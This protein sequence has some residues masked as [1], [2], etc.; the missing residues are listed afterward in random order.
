MMYKMVVCEMALC[1]DISI[2]LVKVLE[3]ES[4]CQRIQER[5]R[6]V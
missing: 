6:L 1:Y 5:K 2:K 3:R 4:R